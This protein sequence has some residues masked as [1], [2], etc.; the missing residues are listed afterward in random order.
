MSVSQK[1]PSHPNQLLPA[2]DHVFSNAGLVPVSTFLPWHHVSISYPR[3]VIPCVVGLCFLGRL[4]PTVLAEKMLDWP[5]GGMS[6][7]PR[8]A[9]QRSWHC[10]GRGVAGVPGKGEFS[11]ELGHGMR[12]C[13]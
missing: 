6:L 10:R 1:K 4:K 7:W 8:S 3:C 2:S 12:V 13:C 5:S 9:S 11:K